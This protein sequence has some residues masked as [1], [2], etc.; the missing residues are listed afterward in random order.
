MNL[1][2]DIFSHDALLRIVT[3]HT[4]NYITQCRRTTFQPSNPGATTKETQQHFTRLS[5][6]HKLEICFT[7]IY[8]HNLKTLERRI[9]FPT[10][11][12]YKPPTVY[13]IAGAELAISNHNSLIT[14]GNYLAIYTDGSGINWRTRASAVTMFSPWPEARPLVVR[15]KRACIRSDQQFTVS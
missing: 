9:S 12:W 2:L 15:E 6:L 13:N 7:A 4:Y 8:Y 5:P 3:G 14:S 1:Q 10:L 11:P